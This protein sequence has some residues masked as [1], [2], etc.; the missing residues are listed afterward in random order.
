MKRTDK[1]DDILFGNAFYDSGDMKL[2]TYQHRCVAQMN[3]YNRIR[4]GKLGL[5]LR[6]KRIRKIFGSIGTGGYV[7]PPVHANF[8]GKNVFIGKNFYANSNLMLVDDGKITIGDNVMIGPNVTIATAIHPLC[9]EE[10]SKKE[11]QRN[12]PVVIGNNVWIA[13]GVTVLPGVTI[14][15]CSVIGAGSVVTKD[16]P[17][18]VLAFGNP[19]RVIRSIKNEGDEGEK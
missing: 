8:G 2:L 13:S 12:E 10:R 1:F 5:M 6:C 3:R 4:S 9:A 19:C 14:G 18:G 11:N 17:A 7:E 15:D 16:V